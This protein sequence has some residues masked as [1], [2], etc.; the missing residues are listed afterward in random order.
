MVFITEVEIKLYFRLDIAKQILATMHWQTGALM[1]KPQKGNAKQDHI[2]T[3]GYD[4]I[5]YESHRYNDSAF[6]SIPAE[7]TSGGQGRDQLE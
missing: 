7:R 4:S 5:V 2:P 1:A 3:G 6:V